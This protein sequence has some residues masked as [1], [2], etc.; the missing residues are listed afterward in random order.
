MPP[1]NATTKKQELL[2][3]EVIA[4]RKSNPANMICADCPK[5]ST[6]NVCIDFASYM[7][8][9][10]AG[11][12]RKFN[13]RI[14]SISIATFTH[15]DVEKLKKGGNQICNKKYL[16]KYKSTDSFKLPNENEID[17]I[18]QYIK[19]KYVDKKWFHDTDGDE[20]DSENGTIISDLD[21]ERIKEIKKTF[22]FRNYV[23]KDPVIKECR[24]PIPP[25]L[26]GNIQGRFEKHS[27]YNGDESLLLL[28]PKQPN[29][30]LKRDITPKLEKLERHTQQ[31][32][33]NLKKKKI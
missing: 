10:C 33:I 17:K 20:E 11:I 22:V 21:P 13:H 27:R 29:W 24:L 5:R 15:E 9:E 32:I 12:H 14:K 26:I 2:T 7:C 19:L 31:S 8:Q 16:A 23:P 4:I 30:D 18:Q 25:N 1:K 28:A 6:S 3:E